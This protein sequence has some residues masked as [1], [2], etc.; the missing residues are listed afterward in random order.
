MTCPLCHIAVLR[1][2]S[3]D[4]VF[5]AIARCKCTT[6]EGFGS[7]QEAQDAALALWRWRVERK[8]VKR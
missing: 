6:G 5:H 4:D 3:G 7:I 2:I 1:L 8:T